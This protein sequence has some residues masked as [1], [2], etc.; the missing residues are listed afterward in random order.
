VG[1]PTRGIITERTWLMCELAWTGLLLLC[2]G[3]NGSPILWS[4]M[5]LAP[6]PTMPLL[7]SILLKGV[8]VVIKSV[9]LGTLRKNG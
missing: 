9:V 7:L 8:L 1:A 2:L 3:W 6:S 5:A 4:F